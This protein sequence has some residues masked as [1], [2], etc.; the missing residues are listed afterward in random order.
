MKDI[1]QLKD[2]F[3]QLNRASNKQIITFYE[4]NSESIRAINVRESDEHYNVQLRLQS[5]YGLSLFSAGYYTKANQALEKSI[6][7]FKKSPSIDLE[8]TYEIGY[9]EEILWNYSISLWESKHLSKSI[10]SVKELVDHYPKNEKY[11]AWLNGLKVEKARKYLSPVWIVAGVW[12]VGNYTF[13]KEFDQ[14]TQLIL[15]YLGGLLFVLGGLY[16]L[17]IFILKKRKINK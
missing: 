17:Y 7:L 2:E 11:Q 5:E 3:E 8:K 14:G 10:T 9:F 4:N 6:A 12:L 16:E 1:H 15:T 13:F